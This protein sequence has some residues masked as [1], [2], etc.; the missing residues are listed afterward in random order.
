MNKELFKYEDFIHFHSS[1]FVYSNVL[2]NFHNI[3][4]NLIH[5]ALILDP[6]NNLDL[7]TIKELTIKN[8]DN[9]ILLKY[10]IGEGFAKHH[11]IKISENHIGDVIIYPP[12]N[13]NF[14][15]GGDLK[16]HNKNDIYTIIPSQLKKWTVVFLPLEIEHEVTP[17]IEGERYAFKIDLYE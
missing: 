17:I 10:V 8:I 5:D 7:K 14:F 13:F 16:I 12:S 3:I 2:D 4:K 15:K 1:L 9:I 6:T 11:H